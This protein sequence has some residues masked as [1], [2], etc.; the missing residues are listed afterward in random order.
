M[1]GKLFGWSRK[2]EAA[3]PDISFGR[4]S[5]NNKTVTKI[6]RWTEAE[7][8]FRENKK[9]ESMDAFF[10]Y[11]LDDAQQNVTHQRSAEGGT[12]ELR[13]GSKIVRGAYNT[14]HLY[15]E[16][17]LARMPKPT[18]PVMRRLLEMNFNLYY[19]RYALNNDR[20]CMRF[21][22]D[23]STATPNKLY[24]GLRELATK[25]DKQDD[26]LV[27]NFA[28]LEAT[29]TGHIIPVPE[30][31]KEIRYQFLQKWVKDTLEY[32]S[33]LDA[34]KLSG[35]IS[36]LLLTLAYRLDYLLVPE[37]PLMNEIEA[38]SDIYFKKD[39]KPV[40]EKN[41]AMIEAFH[42]LQSKTREQVFPFLFRTKNTFSI[43]TPQNYKTI[44]EAIKGAHQNLSWY[45]D[46]N[47]PFI[48]SKIAEYGIS[49]S[50][51]SYSLPKPLSDLFRLFMNVN[52][53]DYFKALGFAATYYD[54]ER[55][56]INRDDVIEE[57][58][59]IINAWRAKYPRLQ[60]N[61][62]ALRFDS[63]LNFNYS[64]T[65]ELTNLRFD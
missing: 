46:N 32:I 37:G 53:N 13:Q 35:G 47:Y 1:L 7:K 5:D 40:A 31:E 42:K 49:Y 51:Y 56:E 8:L 44:V 21:D 25:A 10:D 6:A 41:G 24:Y 11:L 33:S 16:V 39:N 14:E 61:S 45:R 27:Q 38:I 26:L 52:Y 58:E 9:A 4:Y 62:E 34:D 19:C 36:Y 48:A 60:F 23:L 55:K 65:R 22:T 29:D 28:Q 3:N 63:L 17:S 64:F 2:K 18:V 30:E 57:I 43:V 54:A 20:L 15:A 12:F 50:Q 59:D